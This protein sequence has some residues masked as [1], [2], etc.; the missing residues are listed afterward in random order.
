LN[1]VLNR[2]NNMS[3][4]NVNTPVDEVLNAILEDR[5][6]FDQVRVL[7]NLFSS[8]VNNG[9]VDEELRDS[10]LENACKE[11][12]VPYHSALDDLDNLDDPDFD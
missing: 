9:W 3:K 7:R 8:A 5:P 10:M 11:Y 12:G 6:L 2:E 1:N 4:F